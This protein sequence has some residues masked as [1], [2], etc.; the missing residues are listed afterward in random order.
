MGARTPA[1]IAG[2]RRS[3]WIRAIA[4][5][6]LV[7][8][9]GR[10]LG[11]LRA[12]LR[13]GE[14][15]VGRARAADHRS[16]AGHQSAPGLQRQGP[17]RAGLAGLPRQ[18]QQH[19]PQDFRRRANG[20]PR[21]ASPIARP[22]TGSRPWRSTARA[23]PGSPTTATRTAT[24]MSSSRAYAT[25]SGRRGDGRRRHAALRS[26]R[27]GGG[28]C[29]RIASGWP[30]KT[31]APNWGKDQG[32]VIRDRQPGVPLGGV[33]KPQIRCHDGRPVARPRAGRCSRRFRATASIS[34]MSSS[35]GR[36]SC[37]WRPRSARPTLRRTESGR[38][39]I[40]QPQKGYWEYC[41]D[42]SRTAIAG[43]EAV[44][45]AEQQGPIEHAHQRGVGCRRAA[46]GWPGRPTIAS[47]G[48]YHRPL[49]QQVY[50]GQIRGAARGAR[51]LNWRSRSGLSR[52]KRSPAHADEAGDLRAIRGYTASVGGKP[53]PHRARRFPS[54][55]RV[56]L[57]PRRRARR[58]AAGFLPLHDRRGR[59]GFRRVHRSSGRRVALLVVVHAEDDGHVSRARRLRPDLRLRAQRAVSLRP[60]QHVLRQALRL[61]RDAVLP[62]GRRAAVS[63]C[64]SGAEGDEPGSGSPATW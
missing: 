41:A 31:G 27:H 62:E 50:A 30:G 34:R 60:S 19:L 1:A 23:R 11:H 47:Q 54:P 36:G 10:Q 22:T 20:R 45:A 13:S 7:A 21:C 17:V 40:S 51:R 44:R 48:D 49:R 26:A 55:H 32:Y 12:P 25:A 57:G 18:E 42:A 28:G 56:E 64:R 39:A 29:A 16:A 35:D 3:R 15:G 6:G 52:S 14:A 4:L 58:L 9:G 5:G 2:C 38:S 53:H 43:R 59:D 63:S 8:A 61:A 24:T 37:G 46:C 33:R